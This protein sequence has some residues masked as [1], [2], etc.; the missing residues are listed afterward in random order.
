MIEQ[1]KLNQD[2]AGLVTKLRRVYREYKTFRKAMRKSDKEQ[3]R[4]EQRLQ[5]Y[6]KI[7]NNGDLCFDIGANVGNRT[8]VF[9]ALGAKVVA[10]EPQK[11]CCRV[12]RHKFSKGKNF[13]LIDKALDK[14]IR[15]KDFFLDRSHTLSSMSQGWIEAVR[16]SGRFSSHNWDDKIMIETTTMDALIAEYGRPDFCKI[17]VEGFEFNVLQGLSCPIGMISFEFISEFLDPVVKCIEYL[18]KL[19]NASFNYSAGESLDLSLLDWVG[20]DKIIDIIKNLGEGS[21][22]DVYVK[23][24]VFLNDNTS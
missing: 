14:E 1:K 10:V 11:R 9:L 23:F 24:N 22:G 6:S 17:D 12:L 13:Y 3:R 18:S 19:G 21:V 7:I 5:F 20:S 4:H 16:K 8:E 15:Q 2:R